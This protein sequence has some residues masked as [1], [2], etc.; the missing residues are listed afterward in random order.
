VLYVAQ[1]TGTNKLYKQCKTA[2]KQEGK[3]AHNSSSDDKTSSMPSL[4]VL[5]VSRNTVLGTMRDQQ[6]LK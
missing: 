3:K 5:V 1:D 6:N 4:P 2:Y